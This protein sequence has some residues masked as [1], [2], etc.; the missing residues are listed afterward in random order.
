MV[1]DSSFSAHNFKSGDQWRPMN[2]QGFP[3]ARAQLASQITSASTGHYGAHSL[4]R[5]LHIVPFLSLSPLLLPP[6]KG[7]CFC[8]I[9]QT[10]SVRL[11]GTRICPLASESSGSHSL[12]SG[13]CTRLPGV[14]VCPSLGI[15]CDELVWERLEGHSAGAVSSE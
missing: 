14:P 1:S 5:V 2:P 15:S 7:R 6:R 4:Y 9:S 10:P 13:Y 11:W 3:P 12:C 8:P